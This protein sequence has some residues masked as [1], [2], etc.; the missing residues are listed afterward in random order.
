M[1]A[2][3]RKLASLPDSTVLYPVHNYAGDTSSPLGEEKRRNP[4]LRIPTLERWRE[5]MG[6]G[7]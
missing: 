4:Y 1:F 7:V 6:S 5:L 3:L 2:S